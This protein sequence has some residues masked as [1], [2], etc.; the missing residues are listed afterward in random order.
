MM[1]RI[2]IDEDAAADDDD[3]AD[4]D[5]DDDDADV[6]GAVMLVHVHNHHW[7]KNTPSLLSPQPDPNHLNALGS[8]A[9]GK[10][11]VRYRMNTSSY[12]LHGFMF[13][14]DNRDP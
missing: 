9:R 8:S 11:A 4:D 1:M 7:C 3:N 12:A 6:D 2:M 5:D 13:V 10:Q 14:L